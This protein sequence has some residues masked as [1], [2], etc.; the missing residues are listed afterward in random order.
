MLIG[1]HFIHSLC[2]VIRMQK[3][4]HTS[5]SWFKAAVKIGKMSKEILKL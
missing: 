3:K 4:L 2:D 1:V 5:T